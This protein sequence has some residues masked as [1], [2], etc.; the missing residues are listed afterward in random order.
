MS[1]TSLM[2]KNQI[3]TIINI[4]ISLLEK[5]GDCDW[6]ETYQRLLKCW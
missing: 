1:K 2:K 4:K 3:M 6:E 5:R